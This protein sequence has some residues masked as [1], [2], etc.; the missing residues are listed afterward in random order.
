MFLNRES[1][2]VVRTGSSEGID[3]AVADEFLIVASEE[4]V[5]TL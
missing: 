3:V 5:D 4:V 2:L 1:K